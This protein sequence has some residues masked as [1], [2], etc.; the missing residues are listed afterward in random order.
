MCG[1]TFETEDRR[2]AHA[3]GT[4]DTYSHGRTPHELELCGGAYIWV[5]PRTGTLLGAR[6]FPLLHTGVDKEHST[7]AGIG[8]ITQAGPH[9]IAPARDRPPD[10]P[11]HPAHFYTNHRLSTDSNELCG[12]NSDVMTSTTIPRVIKSGLHDHPFDL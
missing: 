4:H 9:L 3:S 10:D 12:M 7:R 11:A 6:A 2:D 1:G 5:N 8:T